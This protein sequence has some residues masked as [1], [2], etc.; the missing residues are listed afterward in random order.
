[1]SNKFFK[2]QMGD[3]F[4]TAKML[5]HMNITHGGTI[6]DQVDSAMGLFAN[7]YCHTRILTGRIDKFVFLKKSY[8]GDHLNFCISLIKTTPKT[9]TIYAAVNRVNLT[10]DKTELIGEAVF[11]YVAVDEN[12]RPISGTIK[13]FKITDPAQ[14]EYVDL[15]IERFNLK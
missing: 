6:L 3:Y 15:I 4:V 5:N 2:R 9:M 13:Q 10:E 8:A 14:K 1:M 11:T 7:S 12:L